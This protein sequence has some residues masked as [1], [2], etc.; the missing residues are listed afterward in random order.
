MFLVR[1]RSIL[2]WSDVLKGKLRRVL[3][4]VQVYSMTYCMW[5]QYVLLWDVQFSY[6]CCSSKECSNMDWLSKEG[7]GAR[8]TKTDRALSRGRRKKQALTCYTP[9]NHCA[10]KL[11]ARVSA[12]QWSTGGVKGNSSEEVCAIQQIMKQWSKSSRGEVRDSR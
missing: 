10:M 5:I 11:A 2:T 7:W 8:S 12:K 3:I 1:D 4:I 9:C 6:M